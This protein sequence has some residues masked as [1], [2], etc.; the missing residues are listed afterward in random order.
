[1]SDETKKSNETEIIHE[2]I[3]S[4][5]YTPK[6]SGEKVKAQFISLKEP[7]VKQLSACATLKQAFMRVIAKQ[8]GDSDG[9]DDEPVDDDSSPM[10]SN[11]I[12]A[13]Y[14]SDTD[15][16]VILLSAKELFRD[17]GLIDGEKKL[18]VPM[19]DEMCIEDIEMMTGKYMANFILASVLKDQ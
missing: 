1:M 5:E 12:N 7:S 3:K 17:V 19:L 13:L 2:L 10:E 11:I 14:A 15:I 9:S 8:Q 18:T 6:N 16:T 4:I